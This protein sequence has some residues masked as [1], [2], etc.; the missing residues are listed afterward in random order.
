MG[1]HKCECEHEQTC[2]SES[3]WVYTWVC[4]SIPGD[5]LEGVEVGG[6]VQAVYFRSLRD[7]HGTDPR[8][9]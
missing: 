8:V 3:A 7:R 1:E 2:V 4:D 6:E 5:E 9:R